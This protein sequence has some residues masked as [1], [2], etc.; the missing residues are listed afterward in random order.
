MAD[1][2]FNLIRAFVAVY[3]T[4][5]VS[6]AALRMHVTQPSV[7][8]SLARLR[9][10]LKQPLFT[11]TRQGMAPTALAAEIYPGLQSALT[12]VESAFANVLAFDPLRSRRVFKVAMTEFGELV[13]LPAIM[14][15]LATLA[16][17]VALDVVTVQINAVS[18]WL[19]RGQVD[20]A[21]CPALPQSSA[22]R[23]DRIFEESYQCIYRA[24]HPRLDGPFSLDAYLAETHIA[25]AESAGH[26]VVEASWQACGIA[27]KVA[28][29]LP[30]LG[31]LE[32]IV[33]TTDSL[34]VV[35]SRIAAVFAKQGRVRAADLPYPVAPFDVRLHWWEHGQ[36]TQEMR[37]F[38][39]VLREALST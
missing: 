39:G 9:D 16:P 37:W 17:S 25:V 8:H 18:E 11:R 35:P 7:S 13:F 32:G 34:A 5:S 20:V 27:P 38:R 3:E 28:L 10:L 21:F 26:H 30:S 23:S 4:G 24:A 29:R 2:D 33:A 19:L 14:R 1:I 31:V 12:L 6:A 36:E 15:A 22:I